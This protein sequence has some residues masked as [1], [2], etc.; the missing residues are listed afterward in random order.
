MDKREEIP[1]WALD[2]AIA[3]ETGYEGGDGGRRLQLMAL[4][5]SQ[6]HYQSYEHAAQIVE[7]YKEYVNGWAEDIAEDIRQH[8]QKGGEND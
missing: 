7:T 8:S 4:A 3:I 1:Q 6:V 2:I 5:L